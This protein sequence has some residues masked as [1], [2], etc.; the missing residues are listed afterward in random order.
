MINRNQFFNQY[1]KDSKKSMSDVMAAAAKTLK[2][3]GKKTKVEAVPEVDSTDESAD[4]VNIPKDLAKTTK[5]VFFRKYDTYQALLEVTP[6]GLSVKDC[7][8]KVVLYVMRWFRNRLGDDLFEKYPDIAYLKTDYPIPEEYEKFKIEN[9]H[10]IEGLNFLD[11]ET[12]YLSKKTAWIFRL[13]E[14]DNGQ[15]RA[16]IQGRTFKTE[17]SVYK[18][19]DAVVLG[20]RE[21]CRELKNNKEDAFGYRPGFVR[22]IFYDEQLIVSEQGIETRYAFDVKPIL[23]N[24]KSKEDCENI[25]KG[26]IASKMRQ[27]PVL[28]IPDDFYRANKMD[29]NDKTASLLGYCHVVVLEN[30]C[31]KLFE[32][33]M[34]SVEF[35][36][37]LEENQLIFYRSTEEQEYPTDYY[38]GEVEGIL[39]EIKSVAMHEPIR[40]RCDFREFAFE[41]ST[42]DLIEEIGTEERERQFAEEKRKIAE[43]KELRQ[44]LGDY[45][46]D[47]DNLQRQ[48]DKLSSENRQY[49]KEYTKNIAAILRQADTIAGNE[50]EIS[51]LRDKIKRLEGQA[52]QNEMIIR[53]HFRE[54]KERTLPLLNIPSKKDDVLPWVRE[55]YSDVLEV[56]PGAE[57][58]FYD[59]NRN[60]DWHKF[61]MMIHYLAGYTK[62]RNGGGQAINPHAAREYDPEESS[63]CVD[64]VSS[65]QG[66]IDMYKDKYTIAIIGEDG[67]KTEKLLDMHIKSGKGSDVN[68]IR[69][70][71]HYSSELRKSIIGYMPGHLPTRKDAH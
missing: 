55:W 34:N 54:E 68:M 40:K 9:I 60:I 38:D 31:R 57:K 59:D 58:S 63:Y 47:N 71:F 22:D 23:V 41:P 70:Y 45:E 49:E 26:L 25:Y 42:E 16:D 30:T 37:V 53:G 52:L 4:E 7:F 69:I 2:D 61:C 35:A 20:I 66:A 51:D 18:G 5:L 32:I 33:I 39:S 24:G 64:P 36:E 27:M 43:I 3:S 56:N 19:D 62:Y 29:V 48:N 15:E 28:F 46:R 12:T 6:R 17:I 67:V 1:N 10:N 65:G 13:D 14:P 44:K 21:S 50:S 11:L 8:S